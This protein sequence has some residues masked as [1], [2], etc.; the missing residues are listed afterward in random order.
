[1]LKECITYTQIFSLLNPWNNSQTETRNKETES[2]FPIS[3]FRHTFPKHFSPLLLFKQ[4]VLFLNIGK[5]EEIERQR[6]WNTLCDRQSF[7]ISRAVGYLYYCLQMFCLF[8]YYKQ[9]FTQ[10]SLKSTWS[11]W[12]LNGPNSLNLPKSQIVVH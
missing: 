1:M 3:S 8:Y 5:F 9:N 2:T 11:S 4:K 7:Q 10:R 12:T 6:Q